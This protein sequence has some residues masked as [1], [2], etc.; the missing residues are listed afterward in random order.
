MSFY[1]DQ[2]GVACAFRM[3]MAAGTSIAP[4]SASLTVLTKSLRGKGLSRIGALMYFAA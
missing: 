4:P 2:A 3:E 1:R